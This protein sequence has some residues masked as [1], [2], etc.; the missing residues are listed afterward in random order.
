MVFDPEKIKDNAKKDWEG[1]WK[2]TAEL[3]TGKGDF[4]LNQKKGSEHLLWK[5]ALDIRKALLE[6]GFDEIVLNPIQSDEEIKKQY[7]PEAGAIMDRV[8]YI[9]TI[10]RPDIGLSNEKKEL[11]LK[12]I[13]DFKKFT[14]LQDI[15]K[16]YK[17]EEI[18]GGEDFTEI[19]VSELNISTSDS[20]YL[21][22]EVFKELTELKPEASNQTLISHA[23]TAWFPILAK[24]QDKKKHPIMLFS[25]VWRY[26]REQK[27]DSRHLKAHLNL[28][29][30]IMDE[31]FKIENGKKLTET[32][33]KKLGFKEVKFEVKP[34]QPTYYA[35]GTN[36]EVFVKHPK[37]GW[38]EVS[39]IG[40][41]SPVSLANY[42]IKYPVFNSGPGLGRIVMALE[43]IEDIR[44]LY[45]SSGQELSDEQIAAGI[46]IDKKPD[47]TE[48]TEAIK[49]GII[50]HKDSLGIVRE[51]VYEKY[52]KVYVLEPE[53]GKKLLG[54]GGMN[55][56]YVYQGN[57]LGVKPEDK[58]YKEIIE[59]GVKVCSFLDAISNYFAYNTEKGKKGI[60]TVKYADTLPSINLK[61]DKSISRYMTDCKKEINI[62]APIFVDIEIC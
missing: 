6:L 60:L 21:I 8:Y 43:N 38:L 30:T 47:N 13:P 5:Y 2:R 27:E 61:M 22:K 4:Q 45:Y 59:N 18:E 37:T 51:K 28:S 57:I 39:E 42:K 48:I 55:E 9:S 33:F 46:E 25:L 50:E 62:A 56:I 7:G 49:K 32:F 10:P 15:L 52:S 12:K 35:P 14:E 26:R 29:L 41:Y 40:M 17:R 20:V 53:E 24:L 34:N 58:K 3:V 16:R 11:I 54:P 23:T 44:E 19:L 31:N 1:E 36:F